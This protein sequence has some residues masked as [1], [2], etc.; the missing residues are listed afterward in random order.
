M[1]GSS[2]DLVTY[3]REN[4]S[5]KSV[6]LVGN[7]PFTDD[8]SPFIDD[9]EVVVRF[10]LFK[11]YEYGKSGTRFTHWV[12]NHRTRQDT[13]LRR[14]RCELA[15][16]MAVTALTPYECC[17]GDGLDNAVSYYRQWGIALLQPDVELIAEGRKQPSIGY[18]MA[19]YLVEAEV[20][21]TAIGYTGDVS[22]RHDG[23]AEMEDLRNHPLIALH[24]M[25]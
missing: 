18:Y 25:S 7:A 6:V 3:I 1:E 13:A 10:N 21:F 19:R 17:W 12:L 24:E 23:A 2:V 20:K 4:L 22:R 15:L 9:H 8:R 14:R 16:R 5:G 11:D